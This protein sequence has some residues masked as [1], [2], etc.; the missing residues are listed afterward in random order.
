MWWQSSWIGAPA[1][2]WPAVSAGLL[3]TCLHCW[4]ALAC[5]VPPCC[6]AGYCGWWGPQPVRCEQHLICTAL[7][8]LQ[9]CGLVGRVLPGPVGHSLQYRV[10]PFVRG[11]ATRR[12]GCE[13]RTLSLSSRPTGIRPVHTYIHVVSLQGG[14]STFTLTV[15]SHWYWPDEQSRCCGQPIVIG[16]HWCAWFQWTYSSINC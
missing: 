3:T 8:G 6:W 12:R 13:C 7:C 2:L 15:G 10:L 9:F 14:W 11:K 1:R 4:W 16:G 5:F